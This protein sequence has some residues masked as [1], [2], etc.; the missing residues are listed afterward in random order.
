MTRWAYKTQGPGYRARTDAYQSWAWEPQRFTSC[1][2]PSIPTH[3]AQYSERRTWCRLSASL[4]VKC[5]PHPPS[6]L[7]GFSP[8]QR[9][10]ERRTR[11]DPNIG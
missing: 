1:A 2:A 7:Y 6:Q 3:G 10:R 9:A 11:G 8:A 5:L 4:R